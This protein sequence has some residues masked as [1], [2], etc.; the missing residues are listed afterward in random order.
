M[1]WF[2]KLVHRTGM[3]VSVLAVAAGSV[4]WSTAPS[5]AKAQVRYPLEFAVAANPGV[6]TDARPFRCPRPVPPM[7]DM[8]R[9]HSFYKMTSTQSTV[10]P[11]AMRRMVARTR[12]VIFLKARLIEM[13]NRYLADP[14]ARAAVS[15]CIFAQLRAWADADALLGRIDDNDPA[16]HRQAVLTAGWTAIA[17]TNAYEIASSEGPPSN[18]D[19][20]IIGDWLQRISRVLRAEFTPPSKREEK[21]RWL[22]DTANHSYWAAAIIGSIG[23]IRDDRSARDWAMREL[24]KALAAAPDDGGLPRELARGEKGLHYQNFALQ[25]L[26][27]LV[28][29]ADRNGIGLS[30]SEE[31]KLAAIVDFTLRAN[32]DPVATGAKLGRPQ[33]WKPDAALWMPV[34]A[35]H[36]QEKDPA[37]AARLSQALRA[38]P[39]QDGSFIGLPPL[40]LRSRTEVPG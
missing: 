7:V 18:D 35:H 25:A 19:E 20:L 38:A 8:S 34:L 24:R 15:Q 22:D 31:R 26:S 29:F 32:A 12:N 27:I 33:L 4:L 37:L 2:P 40:A 17:I 1:P 14:A 30:A 3:A 36:F 5:R 9:I 28:S 21:Y 10:D 16:T 23:A 39:P 11:E 6:T 13:E